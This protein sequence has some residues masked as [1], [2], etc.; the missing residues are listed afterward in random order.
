MLY[1][2]RKM[3]MYILFPMTLLHIRFVTESEHSI[4]LK[5]VLYKYVILYYVDCALTIPRKSG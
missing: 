2:Y 5:Y 4:I 1:P 3:T